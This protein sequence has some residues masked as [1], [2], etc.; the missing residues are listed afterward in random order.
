MPLI[1]LSPFSSHNDTNNENPS[2]VR[3]LVEMGNAC[4]KRD[5]FFQLIYHVVPLDKREKIEDGRRKF[6]AQPL[7]KKRKMSRDEK[8][9]LGYYDGELTKNVI[10]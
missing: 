6:F 4:K 7:E 10:R 2:T 8:N 3:D 5:F 9:L 1:D